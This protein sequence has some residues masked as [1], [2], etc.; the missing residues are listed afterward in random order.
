MECYSRCKYMNKSQSFMLSEGYLQL[1]KPSLTAITFMAP[2]SLQRP[3]G[4]SPRPGNPGITE[5]GKHS[6]VSPSAEEVSSW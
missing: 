2:K 6:T 4:G 1:R 3:L 5:G